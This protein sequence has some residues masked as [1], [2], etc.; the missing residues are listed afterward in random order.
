MLPITAALVAIAVTGAFHAIEEPSRTDP[1]YLSPSA[2]D[3]TGA[4]TLASRLRARGVTIS[5]E[6][7]T[8]DAL[9]KA[10]RG[11]ATL[12]I[13][14]P[15]LM[16]WRYLGM[17]RL[18]PSSTRVVLV[19]PSE[20][21]LRNGRVPME[22]TGV[23]WSTVATAP[24]GGG[25]PIAG[26]ADAGPAA[27]TRSRYTGPDV[28]T[29]YDQGLVQAFSGNTEVIAVGSADIFRNDRIAEH[30]NA[31]LAVGLLATKSTV[32]WLDLHEAEPGPLVDEN[33]PSN[34]PVV[35][36]S[37]R[38]GD[39]EPEDDRGDGQGG[40]P[41]PQSGP[42]REASGGGGEEP[43]NIWDVFPPALWAILVGLLLMLLL[44]ALWRAR[45]L[46]RP[47]HEPL[48]V[49]VRGS[50]T[51]LG[52]ARLYQRA[53]ATATSLE[54]LRQVLR[55]RITEALGLPPLTDTDTL[56]DA[57]VARIGGDRE[58]TAA[59]LGD[60]RPSTEREMLKLARL[61]SSISDAV[62]GADSSADDQSNDDQGDDR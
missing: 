6:T 60:D 30:D 4:D 27:V 53:K 38:P 51:L 14:T 50:E 3:P 59:A 2:D 16:H 7:R 57:V 44:L 56:A 32:I 24:G 45:R 34:G 22:L 36:P 62:R 26:T 40:K 15:G 25:C 11:D 28:V 33:A 58:L 21:D 9:L 10:T 1:A 37:L 49:S 48:P 23:A 20:L 13:T 61:L 52:R 41:T 29:C 39:D 43:P 5:R 8:S 12:V 54:T 55:P 31:T 17:L 18:L 46:G 47:V 42:S 19:E 35:P